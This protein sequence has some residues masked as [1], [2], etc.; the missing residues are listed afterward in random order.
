MSKSQQIH[1]LESM[2][3]NMS[4][5][6]LEQEI[7]HLSGIDGFWGQNYWDGDKFTVGT[8]SKKFKTDIIDRVVTFLTRKKA[9]GVEEEDPDTGE[10]HLTRGN[11]FITISPKSITMFRDDWIDFVVPES[12]IRRRRRRAYTP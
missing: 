4:K 7:L 2:N 10:I 5:R 8:M 3:E 6:D 1:K 12:G 9:W 11:D